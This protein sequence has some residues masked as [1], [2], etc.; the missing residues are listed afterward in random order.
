[1]FFDFLRKDASVASTTFGDAD[2]EQEIDGPANSSGVCSS[3]VYHLAQ[4]L[5]QD[6]NGL[7]LE[8]A[9]LRGTLEDAS[10]VAKRQA[11]AFAGLVRQL[12]DIGQA[13]Q[14]IQDVSH[15]SLSAVAQAREGVDH[16]G[17]EVTGVLESL[18][19]VAEAAKQITQVALQTRLVAFNA[20][21]EAK[22]A[23]EAGRGF[24]VV[25]DAVKDLATQVEGTS[26][27][28]MGTVALLDDRIQSLS[29]DLLSTEESVT[30]KD[31]QPQRITF[32][33]AMSQ[34]EQGVERVSQAADRSRSVSSGINEQVV[35]MNVEVGRTQDALTTALRR[36][37]S[38][39]S[40][41]ERLMDL[42]AGCGVATP[43][44]P[45]IELAQNSA[46]QI[47]E[48]LQKAVEGGRISL[49]AL[50][51]SAIAPCLARTRPNMLQPSII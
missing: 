37:E 38:V 40:V 43:D 13:Q 46:A 36:S 30:R 35:Q 8:A 45:Y 29:R 10:G 21:V 31:G 22:R 41:S 25:A 16:V 26:K 23:G 34:V 17:R 5:Q 28:I 47:G 49:E 33:H 11:E 32:H 3:E 42:I 50:L 9:E 19:E 6:S 20:S 1:M 24:S 27:A 14:Q 2:R 48:A 18:H 44:T 51:T 4:T 39:L 7:G 12:Q 15:L